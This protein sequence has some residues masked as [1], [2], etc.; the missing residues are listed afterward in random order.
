M[1]LA[2][3]ITGV[4]A[5]LLLIVP[6]D[7]SDVGQ[8]RGP[9]FSQLL[10]VEASAETRTETVVDRFSPA[11]ARLS[12]ETRSLAADDDIGLL[13]M[14][15]DTI[16]V[17]EAAFSSDVLRFRDDNGALLRFGAIAIG[18]GVDANGTYMAIAFAQKNHAEASEQLHRL[19]AVLRTG[20]SS[21]A[22]RPWSDVVSIGQLSA[23]GRVVI[24][25]LPTR[26]PTLWLELERTP[27]T[28][29]WWRG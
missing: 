12:D 9:L 21:A 29:L 25:V 7:Q 15:F 23:N 1:P 14:A 20:T 24:A 8:R 6:A 27:D 2:R 5:A 10:R 11:A 26:L 17:D 13:A 28:L 18:A 19:E 4:A 3:F 16:G 22:R